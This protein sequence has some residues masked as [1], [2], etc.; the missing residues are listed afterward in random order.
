MG[1]YIPLAINSLN[2]SPRT[3]NIQH[4]V[5]FLIKKCMPSAREKNKNT[6]SFVPFNPFPFQHDYF[7]KTF[8]PY[9][10]KLYNKFEPSIRNEQD[11]LE[12]KSR[13]KTKYNG[14]KVKHNSRGISKLANSLHKQ[15]RLGR[16]FLA[17]HSY[18]INLKNDNLC[19]CSRPETTP[20]FFNCFLYQQELKLLHE[21]VIKTIPKFTTYSLKKQVDIFLQGLNSDPDPRNIPI[22]FAVQEYILQ[23]NPPP[24]HPPP[25]FNRN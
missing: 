11:L 19:I 6:R 17:A 10:T 4:T 15:L 5:I 7:S 1:I 8:F 22:V 14:Q 16:S 18:V 21:K 23:T 24:P 25:A 2:F 20:H 13:L 9:T 3:S 12:F